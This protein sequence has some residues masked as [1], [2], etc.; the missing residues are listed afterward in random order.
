[1]VGPGSIVGEHFSALGADEELAGPS[2]I[3]IIADA[4]ADGLTARNRSSR[5][6]K[7]FTRS[8][9]HSEW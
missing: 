1:M 4:T 7:N 3:V 5:E 2:E 9:D 8:G 6:K